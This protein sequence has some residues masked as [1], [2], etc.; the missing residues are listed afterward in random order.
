MPLSCACESSTG[1]AGSTGDP[2]GAVVLWL[3]TAAPTDWLFVNGSTFDPAAYPALNSL[4]GGSTLPD[5]R[6]RF[7]LG[8]Y[9]DAPFFTN[10]NVLGGTATHAHTQPTHTHTQPAHIHSAD[11]P[12]TTSSAAG[13]VQSGILGLLVTAAPAGHTH[14]TNI[15]SFNTGSAGAENTGSAGNENTGA[16][17]HNPPFITVNFIVRA[18]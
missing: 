14:Q 5:M 17:N 12:N 3:T 7:P 10:P 4:W 9:M 16:T 6:F 1:P 13:S 2:I 11:P 8:A 18:R 15:P